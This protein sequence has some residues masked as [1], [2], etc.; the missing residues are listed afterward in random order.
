[1]LSLSNLYCDGQ[2]NLEV[3]ETP[4]SANI[5]IIC[6]LKKKKKHKRLIYAGL[7]ERVK[8]RMQQ[9]FVFFF[10]KLYAFNIYKL[11]FVTEMGTTRVGPEVHLL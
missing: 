2:L 10:F 4:P 6:K 1:M 3:W 8:I 5:F 11:R 9:L 7:G